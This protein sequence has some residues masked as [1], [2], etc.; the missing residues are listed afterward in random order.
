MSKEE[1]T[2]NN[3][4]YFIKE[5]NVIIDKNELKPVLLHRIDILH[6]FDKYELLE[7]INKVLDD[8]RYKREKGE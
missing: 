8:F 3:I 2:I 1:K 5:N 7:A 6:D 4:G